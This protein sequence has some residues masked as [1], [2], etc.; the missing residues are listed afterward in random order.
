M[1]NLNL[2]NNKE[3]FAK[4]FDMVKNHDSFIAFD[5]E[6]TGVTRGS[7]IIGFAVCTDIEEAYY[8]ALKY[9]D[10]ETSTLKSFDL[11]NE[12]KEFLQSLTGKS[13]IMHNGVFDCSI[14]EQNYN[15]KLISSLHTDTMILAHLIDEN[16]AVGLKDL[17]VSIYGEDS[18][19]EQLE[20]KASVTQNGGVL[21]KTNYELYKADWA[22][23]GRYGAQD[24]VLT[25]KLFYELIPQLADSGLLD[26]FYNDE[27]MPLLRGPT[28]DL[29]TTGLRI[30]PKEL[31]QLRTQLEADCMQAKAYIY[32]EIDSHVKKDYPGTNKRNGFN[33]GSS[34][35]LA[36]LLFGKLNNEFHV[37]TDGGKELCKELNIPL[38]YSFSAKREFVTQCSQQVG[39]SYLVN[40]K[41]KKIGQPWTY[42]AC[43]KEALKKFENKYKWVAKYLEYA[44]NLKLLNT[45]VTGIETRCVYN[46]IYP[47]FLQHGTTS[48]RYSSRNPNFQNLP[49]NDKR[50]KKCIVARP[51]K[52]F[53]GADYSQLEPRVFASFSKD[54]K[55]MSCFSTGDDFYSVIGASVFNKNEFS[56][57]KDEP[58]SFANSFPNLRDISKVVG[59][60]ATYGTTAFK[61]ASAIGKSVDE[62]QD[63]IDSY[64]TKFPNVELFMLA[65]H[66]KAKTKGQV[67]NLFGRPRRMPEAIT[68]VKKYGNVSHSELPYIARNVLNLAVNH[69]IQS[70]GASIMNRAAIK[71]HD[72]MQKNAATNPL[73]LNAKIVS[74]IHDEIIL[75]VDEILAEEAAKDLQDAMENTVQLPGVSLVAVPKIAN[76]LADLK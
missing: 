24:T 55:L 75:E 53:V 18:I 8:V 22:L 71:L 3:D 41:V 5:T 15:V 63:V 12:A 66:D 34:K 9:W 59:L 57:K 60:S 19:Q 36:W 49:R 6:T 35:Q 56:L 52:V 73:W 50:I 4:L 1:K 30:D 14:V 28:Y 43:G 20:M 11:E 68:I 32:S 31:Q 45:Y 64:F 42:M 38:P 61:M 40:G 27:S 10:K 72:K 29:N 7:Q 25:L 16:R 74:Q 37:L 67:T 62:A 76:C 65:C 13:L 69:T 23:I 70:T 39:Q 54:E 46:T 44:K 33:I 2:I 21:T 17:S 58:N 48:G 26:F 51:G 47:S